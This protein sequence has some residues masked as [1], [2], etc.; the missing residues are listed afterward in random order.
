MLGYLMLVSSK[1]PYLYLEAPTK[2]F[3]NDFL[4][5]YKHD[6]TLNAISCCPW[7]KKWKWVQIKIWNDVKGISKGNGYALNT[8]FI[9]P[10]KWWGLLKHHLQNRHNRPFK[11]ITYF[12][13]G[14]M[15]LPRLFY[16]DRKKM[17]ILLEW[18]PYA[19]QTCSPSPR[20]WIKIAR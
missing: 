2:R 6:C 13:T 14:E 9:A 7:G 5:Q 4:S 8:V 10:L 20:M 12:K 17:K 1:K 19:Q 16:I 15:E 3:F 18:I 11:I